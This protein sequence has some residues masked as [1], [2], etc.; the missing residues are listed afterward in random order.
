[1]CLTSDSTLLD[2]NQHD[3]KGLGHGLRSKFFLN[4]FYVKNDLL[5]HFK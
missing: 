5:V 1:M 3:L 4:F 2:R